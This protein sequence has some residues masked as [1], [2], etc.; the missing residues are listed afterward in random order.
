MDAQ[1]IVYA[2]VR[3]FPIG[4]KWEGSF[5]LAQE[6][7]WATTSLLAYEDSAVLDND[8]DLLSTETRD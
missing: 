7:K 8:N 2:F 4:V 3:N 5:E 1:L 6:V